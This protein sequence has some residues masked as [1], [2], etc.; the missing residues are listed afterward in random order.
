MNNHYHLLVTPRLDAAVSHMIRDVCR[1]YVP[2]HNLRRE[3]TGTLWDGRHWSCAI[4]DDRQFLACSRYVEMNPVR[5]G[6]ARHPGG[7]RW[8]SH[9]ANALGSSDPLITPHELYESLG[10]CNE[11]RRVAYAR[12][13][14]PEALLAPAIAAETGVFRAT[15]RRQPRRIAARHARADRVP[16]T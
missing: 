4:P 14:E 15:L 2:V 10:P 9:R 13:F 8:S 3:R 11:R 12:L 5:A 6:L 1:R 7:F 16:R